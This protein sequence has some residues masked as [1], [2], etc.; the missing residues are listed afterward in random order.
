[1]SRL[2]EIKKRMDFVVSLGH[3]KAEAVI[4][5]YAPADI[6]WL[7]AEVECLNAEVKRLRDQNS[8]YHQ[9][10]CDWQSASGLIGSCGDPSNVKPEHARKYWEA[11]EME[12]KRLRGLIDDLHERTETEGKL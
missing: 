7:I 8:E 10:V 9:E 12:V 4:R 11:F 6:C 5:N 3:A 2:Q 1:M